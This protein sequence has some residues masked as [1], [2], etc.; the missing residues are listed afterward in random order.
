MSEESGGRQY[1]PGQESPR[2]RPPR[3]LDG[4]T[5]SLY[6]PCCHS[7][8]EGHALFKIEEERGDKTCR[9][10]GRLPFPSCLEVS[11]ALQHCSSSRPRH[12]CQRPSHTDLQ[13]WTHL[14]ETLPKARMKLESLGCLFGAAEAIPPDAKPLKGQNLC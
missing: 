10:V 5:F 4:G 3:E 1:L 12:T 13:S 7:V 14:N 11:A 9:P 2:C 8:K 6:P